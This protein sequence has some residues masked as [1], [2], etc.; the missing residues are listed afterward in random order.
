MLRRLALAGDDLD[1]AGVVA[2][3]G[4]SEPE[5]FALLDVALEAGVL[6]VSWRPLPVPP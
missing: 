2:L 5:A 4:T 1:P 6:V 3:T